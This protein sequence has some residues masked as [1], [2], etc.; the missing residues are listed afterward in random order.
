MAPPPIL[1]T[2]AD[3]ILQIVDE[4]PGC[5]TNHLDLFPTA[6][7]SLADPSKG[8][9]DITWDYV[10]CP[11]TGPLEIHMKSGVSA[12]WFSAQVVNGHRRTHSLDVSIDQGK[13]WKTTTRQTYNFFEISSGAG[14]STAWVRATSHTETQVIVKNV[15]MT[16]DA[17]VKAGSNYA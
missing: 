10:P 3:Q 4:C 16:G 11:V 13:T 8:V 15:P 6:F 5:G 12:Y 7:S 14:A 2:T 1:S 17:V 9:I